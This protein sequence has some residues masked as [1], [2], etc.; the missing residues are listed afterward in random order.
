MRAKENAPQPPTEGEAGAAVY[1]QSVLS[2]YDWFVLGFSNRVAWRCPT[3]QILDFYDG[4]VS[5]NHLDVGVGTG[6]FLDHCRFPAPAPRLA[7]LD[8]NPNSLQKTAARLRRYAPTTHVADVLAPIRAEMAPFDS[9][10]LNYL[11]HCLP[12]DLCSKGTVFA[13]LTPFLK[14]GG[15]IF[16]TTILGEGVAHNPVG[17]A[18]MGLYNRKGIFGNATDRLPDLNATLTAHFRSHETRIVGCVAFFVG[19]A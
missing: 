9:I 14:P 11:L 6:Y 15:V 3:P 19:R 12:G 1:T 8:L 10:G 18:L 7:L 16:G 5:A 17:R 2:I 13:R 4:H